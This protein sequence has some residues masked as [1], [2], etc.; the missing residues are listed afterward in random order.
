M[1]D[2]W[3]LSGGG[4]A[5]DDVKDGSYD[6]GAGGFELI[7]A[8]TSALTIIDEAKWDK[9]RDG[10]RYISLRWSMLAPESIKNRKVFQKLWVADFQPGA[11][12][13]EKKRDNAKRMMAAIATNCG[14]KLLTLGRE[15]TDEDL[16]AHLTNK[17]MIV[18]IMIYD[19]PGNNGDRVR[20]NFIAAVSP[21][22]QGGVST[23]QQVADNAKKAPQQ[24]SSGTRSNRVEDDEIPF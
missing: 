12:D 17:H 15:P 11:K 19:L 14:G 5:A 2:F 4:S 20:G 16:F 13:P 18:K 3:N 21:K 10:N 1:S 23:D 6:T 24:Q 8:D 9:D 22:S 7:P